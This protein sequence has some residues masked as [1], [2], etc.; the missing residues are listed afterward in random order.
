[1]SGFKPFDPTGD[2]GTPDKTNE[3]KIPKKES[4]EFVDSAL[5]ETPSR[6]IANKKAKFNKG[7]ET[8]GGSLQI[9]QNVTLGESAS[10]LIIRDRQGRDFSVAQNLIETTGSS[11]TFVPRVKGPETSTIRQGS[12]TLNTTVGSI[13]WFD[14][15]IDD[16][17]LNQITFRALSNTTGVRLV[18]RR[19]GPLGNIIVITEPDETWEDGDG[20][21]LTNGGDSD[22]PL[23]SSV[24]FFDGFVLHFTLEVFSGTFAIKG[25][26]LAF[27]G[28]PS[29][30]VPYFA[31]LDQLFD[32]NLLADGG[33]LIRRL[34]GD[35]A[36]ATGTAAVVGTGTLF[37]IQLV[38]GESVQIREENF[39]VLSITDD[40]NFTLSANHV[41][42]AGPGIGGGLNA[43]VFA[44][45]NVLDVKNF[46]GTSRLKVDRKGNL[47]SVGDKFEASASNVQLATKKLMLNSEHADT[48]PTAVYIPAVINKTTTKSTVTGQTFIP[49]VL[50]VSN[51]VVVID[52]DLAGFA[53]GDIVL[54]EE[55]DKNDDYYEIFDQVGFALFF[56]GIGLNPIVEGFTGDQFISEVS[57]AVITKVLVSVWKLSSEGKPEH[58]KGSVTP[59]TFNLLAHAAD[60]PIVA[61]EEFANTN[62]RFFSELGL[63][64]TQGWTDTETVNGTITIFADNVFGTQKDVIQ[65]DV[66]ASGDVVKSE[67][68]LTANDWINILTFGMSYSGICR[69][70]KDID[71]QS[72]FSG[73]G[74]SPGND[75]RPSS[76]ESRVGVF[77]SVDATHTT[78]RLDG[79]T[80]VVL[81]GTGGTPEVLK[82]EWFSWEIFVDPTPDAGTNFGAAEMFVNGISIVVGGIIASNNAVSDEISVANSSSTGSTTFFF[83]NFGATIYEEVSIKTLSVDT[84]SSDIAQIF[85]PGGNRDYTV[86]LPDGNPRSL[87]NR[88]DFFLKNIGGKFKLKT[89]N[90]AVPQSLFNGLNEIE[91]NVISINQISLTNDVENGNVYSGD[92]VD[93]IIYDHSGLIASGDDSGPK[94][95]SIVN[96][97]TFRVE[98]IK[99]VIVDR[100]LN[101]QFPAQTFIDLPQTDHVI[102]GG[103]DQIVN[104]YINAQGLF[105]FRADEPTAFSV[106]G[107][108]FIGKAV[109]DAGV[110]TVAVFTPVVAYTGSVDGQAELINGGGHKTSG[111]IL[112]AAGAN[113]TIGVTAGTHHQIGRGF[114]VDPNSPNLCDTP[115]EA[116]IAFTGTT[117]NLF[118]VHADAG[119]NFI[120]DSFISNSA[121]PDIDPAQFNDGGTLATV[122]TNRF[123]AQRVFQACG[124]N[125]IIIYYGTETYANMADAEAGFEDENPELLTTRDV[126]YIC[127]ILIKEN[128][129]NLTT[130]VSGGDVLFK[131]R[132]GDREL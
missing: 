69:I 16:S 17:Q 65:Y 92:F 54:F 94:G 85:I 57:N 98:A 105:E 18:I 83:D 118:L 88:L 84:M 89:E 25:D 3:G 19:D 5:E 129:T 113:L 72:I 23:I 119:G 56:R 63:P 28:Q 122:P 62:A 115:A 42:G 73:A 108:I 128:V 26:V 7:M 43:I 96:A 59:I 39:T 90:T 86:V 112:S 111:S 126:S 130:G 60:V 45:E 67:I 6:I 106:T 76:I 75:P 58:G 47:K 97:T 34:T 41:V 29:A 55:T 61:T 27:G 32:L 53:L 104:T 117:G 109:M 80:V 78:I 110:I 36:I 13:S 10:A 52:D 22:I 14:I 12:D 15:V 46:S 127:T 124:T 121:N 77:I 30:F 71:T 101:T 132:S 33:G 49:G 51:P 102:T 21:S 1:M 100:S 131:N 2:S 24:P 87:G 123:S 68:P 4:G 9:G 70:T 20:F 91:R 125:D 38:V 81:D 50:G 79:Q 40:T 107:E 11:P 82:D 48:T 114:L 99:A 44:E 74:F 66:P 8:T 31:S 35:V 93:N 120:I 64:A 103:G 37:T 116:I 95:M